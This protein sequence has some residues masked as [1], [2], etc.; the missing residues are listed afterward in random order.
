MTANRRH[1]TQRWKWFF[2]YNGSH[3]STYDTH[4]ELMVRSAAANTS[5]DP[6]MIYFG[7]SENPLLP[8][9]E[10]YDVKVLHHAPSI[11]ADLHR[12]KAKFP[13]YPFQ[14]ATGAFLRIDLPLICEERGYSDEFVLYTD[15]DVVFQHDVPRTPAYEYLRPAL[16]A[17]APQRF[18]DDWTNINSGVMVMNVRA[19]LEDYSA[20]RRFITSGDT[21]YHELWK[22]GPF[23]Q[24][25]F[26]LHYQSRWGNLPLEYNW[27]PYW[28]FNEDALVVHFHGPK[29][30]QVQDVIKGGAGRM[31]PNAKNLYESDPEAYRKYLVHFEKSLFVPH[32]AGG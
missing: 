13:D 4:I 25:A 8:L 14:T 21:L 3:S 9:V 18:Q 20:F 26:Q 1:P 27:K 30:P 15:C 2:A 17:C 22:N 7:P 10:S 12:I 5:L 6:H 28:G 29:I 16:F 19:L 24:R 23:D 11:L 31:S 32:D